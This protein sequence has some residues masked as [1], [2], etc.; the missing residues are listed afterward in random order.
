MFP[1]LRYLSL[2]TGAVV[3]LGGAA[4]WL[5]RSRRKSPVERE[6]ERREFINRH[7]RIA[8]G[9]VF[10]FVET[11]HPTDPDAPPAQLLIYEYEISGVQYQAAQDVTE[12]RDFVDVH[13]CRLGLPAS[14][15]YDPIRPQNSM[16]VSETWTGVRTGA[17]KHTENVLQFSP[18]ERK[19]RI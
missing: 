12:L 2:A 18:M 3:L 17:A 10:D 19:R 14:V 6:R 11:P 4:A 8:D 7:G 16:I 5:A 13:N 9:T 15:R 1:P